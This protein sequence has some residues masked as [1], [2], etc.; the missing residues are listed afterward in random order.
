[1]KVKFVAL[2][3][4]E[5]MMFTFFSNKKLRKLLAQNET[6]ITK[7]NQVQKKLD[8]LETLMATVKEEVTAYATQVNEFSNTAAAAIVKVQTALEDLKQKLAS[9]STP[10]EVSAILDPAI[11]S[12][13]PVKDALVALAA[14]NE[15][16]IPEEPL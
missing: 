5:G 7:L 3:Q 16:T 12:L 2:T 11:A 14:A 1:M 9:A 8:R 15:P 6:I 10:E 13:T 4:S